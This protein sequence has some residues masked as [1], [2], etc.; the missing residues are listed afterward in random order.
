MQAPC[1]TRSSTNGVAT[2][3]TASL[4]RLGFHTLTPNSTSATEATTIEYPA[5][6]QAAAKT[7][8]QYVPGAVAI[9]SSAVSAVTLVPGTDGAKVTAPTAGATTTPP[10][11]AAADPAKSFSSTACIS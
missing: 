4:A 11:P 3:A 1:W 5:G 8:A 2:A 7:V 10:A 6:M 9:Q